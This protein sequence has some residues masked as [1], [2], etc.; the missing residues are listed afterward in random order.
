MNKKKILAIAISS[1]VAAGLII[2]LSFYA[3][4]YN[5]NMP[6][7][8]KQNVQVVKAN[9]QSTQVNTSKNE[10]TK[11]PEVEENNVN[12]DS[13]K[14]IDHSVNDLNTKSPNNFEVQGNSWNSYDSYVLSP[15]VT[16]LD[17]TDFD[18]KYWWDTSEANLLQQLQNE[19]E[20]YKDPNIKIILDN[21]KNIPEY[22]I[23]MAVMHPEYIPFVAGYMNRKLNQP[24]D[25]SKYYV[26]GRIPLFEQY[27]KQWGY[28][29]YGLGPIAMD[30]C[31]P[32]SLAMVIVGLT[33]N[34]KIN[35]RVVAEYGQAHGSYT[36]NVGSNALLMT[37]VAEHFGL[38]PQRIQ[39]NQVIENL[40]EG[41]PIIAALGPGKFTLSG[42]VIVLVGITKDGKIIINNPDSVVYS[43]EAWN[44]STITDCARGFWSYTKA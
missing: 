39:P 13:K 8:Q 21:A 11:K 4:N 34:T 31:G 9:D 41:H 19:Y 29:Q 38:V 1:A 24:I 20:K 33:G 18:T 17:K 43:R 7:P 14:S 23:D 28:D 12:K 22:L 5:K 16:Q 42:H 2:G 25:I 37:N 30:G 32:T 6:K 40:K 44:L 26:K 3:Y 35:P 10:N 15:T 27:D 36:P